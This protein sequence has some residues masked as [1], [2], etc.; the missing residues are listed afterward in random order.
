[1][2]PN[3]VY[4]G[5]PGHGAVGLAALLARG[6]P[7]ALVVTSPPPA[8]LT[9]LEARLFARREALLAEFPSIPELCARHGLPCRLDEPGPAPPWETEVAAFR[10]EFGLIVNFRRLL[11]E[12]IFA[13][14]AHGTFNVHPS[15]LPRGRGPQPVFWTLHHGDPRSGFTVHQVD[16][17]ADTGPQLARRE[18]D[19]ADTDSF[20]SL[21]RRLATLLPELVV[22]TV[23]AL[24]RGASAEPVPAAETG[25][26][27]PMPKPEDTEL[28]PAAQT[29]AEAL[30]RIRAGNPLL[31]AHFGTARHHLFIW[32]ARVVDKVTTIV[33]DPLII[34]GERIFL[35]CRD[36]LLA[37]TEYKV[38][39]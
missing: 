4:Y 37:L 27:D 34:D 14:P 18:I 13:L 29:C 19:V 33:A 2:N 23:E 26:F 39:G 35:R 31:P 12:R 28:V 21:Y 20:A 32:N 7:P 1:M 17:G 3:F 38:Y 16:A 15:L 5:L 24:A 8:P 30:R 10:P 6:L 9:G 36:G 25:S 22:A 11:P